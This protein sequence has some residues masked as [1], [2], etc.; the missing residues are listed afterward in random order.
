MER[1]NLWDL[2]KLRGVANY[3]FGRF[4]G[5][6]LFPE[7]IKITRSSRTGKIKLIFFRK[8]L[9]ATLRNKDGLLSLNIPGARRILRKLG[10]KTPFRV[11]IKDGYQEFMRS[12]RNLFAK[13]VAKADRAIRPQ[14]EVIILDQKGK[15]L[16]VGKAVL[17]G[18]EMLC[19]KLGVAA[20]VR[21]GVDEKN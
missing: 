7:G 19:F 14:N 5:E 4:V 16:A 3:Q 17:S 10:D 2:R 1:A 11:I 9:L 8:Q 6:A 20:K 12:G 15:L 13:H 21:R 18:D